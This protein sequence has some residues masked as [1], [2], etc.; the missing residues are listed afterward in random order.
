MI[1]ATRHQTP[2]FPSDWDE[3][4]DSGEAFRFDPMHVPHPVSP[5]TQS[6]V[7]AASRVGWTVA[8]R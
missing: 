4:F 7:S 3:P 2:T 8:A 5:L 1:V 6:T